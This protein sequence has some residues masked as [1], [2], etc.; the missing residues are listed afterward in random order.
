MRRLA[1]LLAS[2]AVLATASCALEVSVCGDATYDLPEDRGV[3]CASADPVPPGTA[4]PLKGDKASSDCFENLP[5]YE[6]NVCVATEDAVCAL[7][8]DETWGCVFPSIGCGDKTVTTAA[9]AVVDQCETWDYD[10]DDSGANEGESLFD[11]NDDYDESWFVEVTKVT[12]LFAC[13]SKPTPAPTSE[14]THE[15]DS[16]PTP[17]PSDTESTPAPTSPTNDFSSS[18]TTNTATAD[19]GVASDSGAG[20]GSDALNSSEAEP[21]PAP[22]S[23][24]TSKLNP[25]L[26]SG[27]FDGTDSSDTDAEPTPAPTSNTAG[28]AS[29][30]GSTPEVTPATT[31]T[32]RQQE[33]GQIQSSGSADALEAADPPISKKT[34]SNEAAGGST[35]T[36]Q[37]TGFSDVMLLSVPSN[38]IGTLKPASIPDAPNAY[39]KP[40][41]R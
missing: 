28:A 37:P 19:S 29:T 20:G 32:E 6:G 15:P 23:D 39:N 18:D 25:E 11:G 40:S 24:T 8:T 21:T 9:P 41:R 16:E 22:T 3:I 30:D 33:T 2:T 13:E 12:V 26:T 5:S 14:S 36:K 35:S 4:C 10:E 1:R 38:F 7:V 27:S 31:Q 34:E 17:T